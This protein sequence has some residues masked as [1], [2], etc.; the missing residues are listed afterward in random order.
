MVTKEHDIKLEKEDD[1]KKLNNL[2]NRSWKDTYLSESDKIGIEF[3]RLAR[4]TRYPD[5]LYLIGGYSKDTNTLNTVFERGES[6][7]FNTK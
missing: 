4:K 1:I 6:F 3:N 7:D 2:V 5:I